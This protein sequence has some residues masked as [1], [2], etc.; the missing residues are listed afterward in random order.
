MSNA[1]AVACEYSQRSR[2]DIQFIGNVVQ[3]LVC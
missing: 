3:L 1:A 2:N